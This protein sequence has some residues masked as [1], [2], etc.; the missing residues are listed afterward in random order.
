MDRDGKNGGGDTT[1]SSGETDDQ[2]GREPEKDSGAG[3]G[4]HAAAHVA[5]EPSE[6]NKDAR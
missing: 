3:Y 5:E 4:N 1:K 6:P 2:M